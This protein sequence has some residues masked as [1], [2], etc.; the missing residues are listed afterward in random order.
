MSTRNPQLGPEMLLFEVAAVC[1]RHGLP[2][3]TNNP[4]AALYHA[5]GMLQALGLADPPEAITAGPEPATTLLP[6]IPADEPH[7]SAAVLAM[8]LPPRRPIDGH[9]FAPGRHAPGQ[10]RALRLAGEDV[11]HG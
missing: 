9:S 4:S 6:R 1:S 2:V 10:P 7:L 8:P 3:Q 5:A 11:D